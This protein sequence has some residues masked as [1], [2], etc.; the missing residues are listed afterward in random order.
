MSVNDNRL[1]FA[2]LSAFVVWAIVAATAVFW[3]LR[4]TAHSPN[5]PAHA[6]AL[7]KAGAA[8]GDLTRLLG[9]TPL[10]SA[11]VASPEASSRFH[12]LGIIAPRSGGAAPSRSGVA[13][14]AVDGNL[15]RAFSVGSSIDDDLVL[16]SV[17]LRTASLGPAQGARAVLLE[18]P[19]LPAPA[20]GVLSAA[21]AATA[22]PNPV[23]V[24]KAVMPA[25]AVPLGAAARRQ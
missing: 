13:L 16:Q 15:A 22:P 1:M 7:G 10:A 25:V 23:V 20:T 21:G 18:L 3:T 4:L 2:R 12:L 9:A 6:I 17:S 19:A 8:N 11:G 5:V 14:I 24:P